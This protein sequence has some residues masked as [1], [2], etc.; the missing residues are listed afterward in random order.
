MGD[1][2][3]VRSGEEITVAVTSD[4]GGLRVANTNREVS[5]HL[6]P[7]EEI[8]QGE[9]KSI[10]AIVTK[11]IYSISGSPETLFLST[12]DRRGGDARANRSN[13]FADSKDRPRKRNCTEQNTGGQVTNARLA[14]S[15]ERREKLSE[16]HRIATDLIGDE[17]FAEKEDE[18]S[19]IEAAKRRAKKQGR[20]P[21]VD[22]R[23]RDCP[24][25]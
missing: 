3:D 25:E 6:D 5:V 19:S 1:L 9:T 11:C 22:P 7:E 14:N 12:G 23:F 8:E 20:D 24:G 13:P 15:R 17:T 16:L 10:T 4:D 18:T 2:D 21:A